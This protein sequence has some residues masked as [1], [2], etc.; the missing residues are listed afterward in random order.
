MSPV[1]AVICSAA[2]AA[3]DESAVQALRLIPFPKQVELGSGAFALNQELRLIVGA[4]NV[5]GFAAGL[6]RAEIEARVGHAPT[7]T[8][9][10]PGAGQHFLLLRSVSNRPRVR[11]IALPTEGGDEG[12]VLSVD[13]ACMVI[14]AKAPA[15]LLW[16]V[17][18]AKQL[19][20]ANMRD[21]RIPALTISDWPS[22]RYRCFQDDLTRGPSS[23]LKQLEQEVEIGAAVKQNL[24]TY[25][26]EHQY[27]F[28]KHPAIGPEGGTLTAE[29]LRQLVAFAK[30][31]GMDI[32]GNQ[33]SFGH[34]YHI[35]K[36]Q[37]YAHLRETGGIVCPTK[38]ES[39]K[40][41]D[42]LYSEQVPLLPFPMFNVCCD[43]THGLGKGPSKE[44]A[45][46]IGVGGVYAGHMRRVHDILKD[47]YGKRMMMW[48]DIILRH[49]EHLK[50]IP[51]DTVMLTWGYGARDS[52]ENQ[53]IPFAQSGYEF[54]V[55]PGVSCW[56]RILP[57]F[58]CATKNIQ[59]FVRDGSKHGAIGM[60]N[61]AWDDDGE[62]FCA[63]N[64]H[65]VLWGAECS[66]NASTTDLADF[67]R[68][69]GGVLFGE[70]GDHFGQAIELLAKTH[71][72]PG[73][74]RMMD[75][76]FWRI[77]IAA[78]PV[79][80]A[81]ARAQAQ[82]LLD[83]VEPAIEHLT[84]AKHDAQT[85]AH[86]LDYFLFGARRMELMA[87]RSPQ[88][89]DAAL[90]YERAVQPGTSREAARK[91]L[92]E[93]TAKLKQLRDTH[94]ALK[95]EYG[96]LWR[97]ENKPYALSRVQ[98]RF[99]RAISKY[100]TVLAKLAKAASDFSDGKPL[101]D[102][103]AVGLRIREL[104]VRR[105]RPSRIVAEPLAPDKP[106]AADGFQSRIGIRVASGKHA[107]VDLP[108][109]LDLPQAIAGKPRGHALYEAESGAPVPCQVDHVQQRPRLTFIVKGSLPAKTEKTFH[110]YLDGPEVSPPAGAGA[111]SCKNGKAGMKWIENG[112]IRLL[113]G[114]EGSHLYRWEVKA[115]DNYDLTQ[116]GE[117]SWSGFADSG[118]PH[119]SLKNT[120]EVLAA[121]PV[122]VRLRC[123]DETGLVKTI[124]AY[125]GVPWIEIV[126]NAAKPWFW[127]YDRTKNFAA[128]GPTPGTYLFSNGR[129]GAVG[130][131]ADGLDAQVKQS[132]VTWSAKSRRDGLLL[133]LI[134]PEVRARHVVA[135]GAG[136]GSVGI[137]HSPLV[138]HFITY[139]GVTSGDPKPLLDALQQTLSLREQADVVLH[140]VQTR[141]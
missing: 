48:G 110:L 84:E 98:D 76:R 57:D 81:V 90:A 43:E 106:W 69:I 30:P 125:A 132:N 54:F 72:L 33:Q 34:F 37:E 121:G 112:E 35:L 123:T 75:R 131:Q 13:P 5:D 18:T 2:I 128:D 97:Q 25:Y 116:P 6:L 73:Y 129:K 68:R 8:K 87:R 65:G 78:C 120:I 77:E 79:S 28:K 117:S 10:G 45:D 20:R 86:L 134:T 4:Q 26:M 24:F 118:G 94:A 83:I 67:N 140:G 80:E 135:P 60:L 22:L 71:A 1:L 17:Q 12:Y 115:L 7:V 9:G 122:L 100:D 130:R 92:T 27:A 52:F 14:Q 74:D 46:K 99:D 82:A 70:K 136:S 21:G 133:A 44:L 93:S 108:V 104:G 138:S 105:T 101:P 31:Y 41:L 95:T 63:P 19:V 119:R 127:N 39:Y 29:E 53:I 50:E 124:S 32:L 114:P 62:S 111:V 38:E 3:Q 56:S 23:L 55:C 103:S 88:S 109:E 40:L 47:K 36:H 139:G 126:L 141:P 66:W 61:T 16:G 107:R 96:R 89:L 91:A 11:V 49:P 137:E 102:P 85:N 42:D 59:N 113:I 51:K 58:S 15:G 64:W